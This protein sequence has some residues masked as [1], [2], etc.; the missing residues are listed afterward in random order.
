MKNKTIPYLIIGLL[1][2]VGACSEDPI[3][4]NAFGT[5]TGKVVTKGDNLPLPNVKIST[6][7][8]STT[9]FTDAEGNFVFEEIETGEY[10]V[11]AE[12]DDFI[13][14]FEGAEVFA[15]KTSNVVFELDSVQSSNLSP[16]SPLLIFPEDGAENIG[17]EVELQWNSSANDDD[18]ILY[19]LE[20]RNGETNEIQTYK[21]LKDTM[22]LVENLPIGK[23]FIWQVS[24]NDGIS[25]VVE[26]A[27][28]SFAT[29][30]GASNRF[31]YTRNVDGNNVVFSGSDPNGEGG[32]NVNE[33]QLTGNDKNS[34]RPMKNNTVGKIAFLRSIGGET[35]I[36]TMNIDGTELTQVTRTIPVAG[37]RQSDLE[38][39][40]HANGAKLFYPN[41]NKLYSINSDGSGNQLVYQAADTVLISEVAVNPTNDLV[42]LKMNN[43][44]GYGA[45]VIVADLETGTE[46]VVIENQAGALGGLDFSIDGNR[47]LY[48]R[49]STGIENAEYR[50]LDSR[51]YEYDLSALTTIEID[52][53]KVPGTNNFDPKYSPD[54]GSIIF[55]STS[56]D[57]ISERRV[58]R[59]LPDD[60]TTGE[61]QIELL[62]VDAFMPNWE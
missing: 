10:S 15:D 3:D 40:W 43:S 58:Y 49:D 56:N 16:L 1:L 42:A 55:V 39:T 9:I 37:F 57:G 21:D 11:Q 34:Y 12:L 35:Q 27:L 25:K 50:Q 8:I 61:A 53:R 44:S 59:T 46:Q 28:S 47:V 52:T 41:F 17:T 7:P 29:R 51:I 31:F 24:A 14:G 20:L 38:F 62:F 2:F 4:E 13:T 26:S 48:T 19:T 5:M 36:F 6:T 33:L 60:Q 45:R 23:N 18:E 22:L 54:D 30:D 32:Q